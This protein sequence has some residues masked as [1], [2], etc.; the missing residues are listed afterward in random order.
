[1]SKQVRI[2]NL[3]K[4]P[5]K[6]GSLAAP[7]KPGV[8]LTMS[9][10]RYDSFGSV[11]HDIVKA[12]ESDKLIK[13]SK[14]KADAP[15]ILPAKPSPKGGGGKSKNKAGSGSGASSDNAGSSTSNEPES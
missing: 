7:L 9:Q 5:L 3:T 12:M 14:P 1:M 2:E 10:K 4:E 13:I 6:L 8:P 11:F 15:A